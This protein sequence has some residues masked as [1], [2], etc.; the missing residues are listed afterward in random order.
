[1]KTTAIATL[2]ILLTPAL[3]SAKYTVCSATLNSSQEREVF[4]KQLGTKDFNFIELT[5]YGTKNTV[6]NQSNSND[7]YDK[8]CEAGVKCDV[9]LISGHFGGSFSGSSN[10]YLQLDKLTTHS[11]K[12]TCAGI[13]SHPKEVYLFGCNT[14]AGKGKDTRDEASY[15]RALVEHGYDRTEAE[16][17]VA[18]RYGPFGSAFKDQME[19]AFENVPLIYGF[20]SIGPS[21]ANIKPSLEKYLKR[22]GN[23]KVHLD[24]I[25]PKTN[26]NKVWFQSMTAYHAEMGVGL[27]NTHPG[28]AIK[29]NSC[30][31]NDEAIPL[32]ARIDIATTLMQDSPLLY[33]PSVAKFVNETYANFYGERAEN[34]LD[35]TQKINYQG[36]ISRIAFNDSIKN[37]WM[38]TALSKGI[39]PAVK[40]DLLK[41]AAYLQLISKATYTLH[42]TEV[43]KNA[44]ANP[45]SENADLIC[46][47]IEKTNGTG[48]TY[49]PF[50][51]KSFYWN[52]KVESLAEIRILKCL[53]VDEPHLSV[54]AVAFAM[55]NKSLM[56]KSMETYSEVLVY[57]SEV[58]GYE[59]EFKALRNELLH[60]LKG[61]SSASFRTWINFLSLKKLSGADQVEALKQLLDSKS[62]YASSAIWNLVENPKIEFE[63]IGMMFGYLVDRSTQ[64]SYELN[65]FTLPINDLELQNWMAKKIEQARPENAL[66]A[67]TRL[68]DQTYANKIISPALADKA[69]SM[70]LDAI[71]N[72]EKSFQFHSF[73]TALAEA[74]ISTSLL[75]Q[76]EYALNSD[77][78]NSPYANY[79]RNILYHQAKLGRI[80]MTSELLTGRKSYWV[81]QETQGGSNCSAIHIDGG[82]RSTTI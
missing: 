47:A 71:K 5:D 45:S 48:E 15:L 54:R 73:A 16:R 6:D 10:L 30:R 41:S 12:K 46:S 11:C 26:A 25:T 24:Q 76:L 2:L 78:K 7:W 13:Q 68:V 67:M 77:Q 69:M 22:L 4:K 31:M 43:F 52:Y 21:G 17:V 82:Q 18:T 35:G 29:E 40:M 65:Y 79:H 62:E 8:A 75:R 36:A 55:K 1:M 51:H 44:I 72:D 37:F 19:R 80:R 14:L 39:T 34:S 74:P 64:H 33:L 63:S 9:L 59:P 70:Y 28:Y 56:I 81:C 60:N 61:P 23:Y 3:A 66:L 38:S 50:I 57:L 27:Y 20:D 53:K 32:P 49:S 42:M 58:R